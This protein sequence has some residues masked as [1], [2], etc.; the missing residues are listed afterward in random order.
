MDEGTKNFLVCEGAI[1]IGT[2]VWIVLI[3]KGKA[4]GSYYDPDSERR[5]AEKYLGKPISKE[6]WKDPDWRWGMSEFIKDDA[7]LWD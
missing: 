1:L 2:I 3:M 4:K 6:E 7:D 5:A